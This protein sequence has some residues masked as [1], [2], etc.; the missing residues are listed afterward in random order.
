[1]STVH[2]TA[3][4]AIPFADHD[5]LIECGACDPEY[6]EPADWDD[7]TDADR[8]EPTPNDI[9]FLNQNAYG[10]EPFEP[11]DQDWDDYGRWAG[12]I[13]DDDLAAAGLPV[14]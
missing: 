5:A 8:Y 11:S 2:D 13:A 7:W 10:S 1:M 3:D 12:A 9:A 4:Y 6:G 14:G